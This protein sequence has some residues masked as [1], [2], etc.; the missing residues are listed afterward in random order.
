M[1]STLPNPLEVLYEPMKEGLKDLDERVENA[2]TM[3]FEKMF[4]EDINIEKEK[5]NKN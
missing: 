4:N 1:T 5:E 3:L 2:F